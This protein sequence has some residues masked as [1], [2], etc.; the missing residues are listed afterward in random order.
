MYDQKQL[1]RHALESLQS[2]LIARQ[3]WATMAPTPEALA[4]AAPF[5]VDT[6]SFPEW[7]QFVCIPRFRALCDGGGALP[8][9][10]NISAMAEYYFKT[11]EDQPIRAAIA[12]ID[13]LLSA[14]S[15]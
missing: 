4:S 7:L 13:A 14:G 5:C 6:L 15:N 2:A 1:L 8:A 11:P 9:N 12:R 10:S 3:Y